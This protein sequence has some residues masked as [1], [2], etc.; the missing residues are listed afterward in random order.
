MHV[1]LSNIKPKDILQYPKLIHWK[2]FR[3]IIDFVKAILKNKII[4]N[5][6]VVDIPLRAIITDPFLP[7][8]LPAEIII[9]KVINGA[10]IDISIVF[11]MIYYSDIKKRK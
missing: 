9:R 11:V 10:N 2:I 5:S 6:R 8:Y 3:L 7:R 1:K 4:D